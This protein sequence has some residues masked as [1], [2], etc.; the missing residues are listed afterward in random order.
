MPKAQFEASLDWLNRQ[1]AGGPMVDRKLAEAIN[2]MGNLLP[3]APERQRR[4][5][6][7]LMECLRDTR[8]LHAAYM[9]PF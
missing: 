3:Y 5:L 2:I 4:E 1:K 9:E 7:L 6:K 8:Q